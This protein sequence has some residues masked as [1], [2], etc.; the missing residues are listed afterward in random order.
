MLCEHL[1]L[2]NKI[3]KHT[4]I[5]IIDTL[6]YKNENLFWDS[7]PVDIYMIKDLLLL[8]K[9]MCIDYAKA[10]YAVDE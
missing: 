9:T 1:R 8:L 2:Q 5:N 6:L 3:Q 4:R 10:I 7:L